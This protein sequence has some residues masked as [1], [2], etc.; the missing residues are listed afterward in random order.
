VENYFLYIVFTR[1]TTA[2]SQMIAYVKHDKYTH[3]SLA[4]D[5][6][7]NYMYSF[8]RKYARNPFIGRF[9]HEHLQQGLYKL[10]K[11]LPGAVLEL[12]VTKEQYYKA[13]SI[14]DFFVE[15]Q[16]RYKYNYLGL[17]HN[18]LK[19]EVYYEN[20]FLCSE[21]VYYVLHQS[22]IIDLKKPRNLV[23]PQEL[24]EVLPKYNAKIIYEGDL[25]AYPT[26]QLSSVAR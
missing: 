19:A 16:H 1:T 13:K 14:I 12:A 11:F 22:N 8:G 9:K 26:L 10:Q 15:H 5:R 24:Y 25:K 4:L 17:I 18:L 6:E 2:V 21:F 3:A 7:L 20:R 23:R